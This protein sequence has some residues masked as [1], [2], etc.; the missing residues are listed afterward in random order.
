VV[1]CTGMLQSVFEPANTEYTTY[2]NMPPI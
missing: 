1:H 2:N